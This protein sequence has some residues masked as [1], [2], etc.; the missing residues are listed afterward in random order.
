MSRERHRE[1]LTNNVQLFGDG[2]YLRRRMCIG[3]IRAPT[4]TQLTDRPRSNTY[5]ATRAELKEY[6]IRWLVSH[7]CAQRRHIAHEYQF[8]CLNE[9][10]KRDGRRPS[11]SSQPGGFLV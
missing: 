10:C 9:L 5:K 6:V 3:I 11:H 2:A 8:H 7:T 4:T 1:C